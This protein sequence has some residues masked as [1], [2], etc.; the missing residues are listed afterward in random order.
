MVIRGPSGCGKTTLLFTAAG[1]LRPNL[2]NVHISGFDFY[3]MNAEHRGH[4][5]ADDWLC[6][7]TV[8]PYS[9]LNRK[10]EYFN[11]SHWFLKENKLQ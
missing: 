10:R 9:L 8:L 5:R 2:G 3:E 1:M 6:I 4:K 11:R 7:P